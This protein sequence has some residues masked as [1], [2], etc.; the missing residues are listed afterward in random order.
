MPP[1]I[2]PRKWTAP[3]SL[4]HA[5]NLCESIKNVHHSVAVDRRHSKTAAEPP[6][7]LP[8][9]LIR[10]PHPSPRCPRTH[11]RG[12]TPAA[13]TRHC[14]PSQTSAE[15]A[16]RACK[17]T[18]QDKRMTTTTSAREN[19][20]M[21]MRGSHGGGGVWIGGGSFYGRKPVE[22]KTTYC[23]C[24]IIMFNLPLKGS[25]CQAHARQHSSGASK[26]L[27]KYLLYNADD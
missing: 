18:A 12:Y 20:W 23:H 17:F 21:R 26:Q 16:S 14:Y 11:L 2:Y 6:P 10:P 24:I 15:D 1:H 22:L 5:R 7:Y 27:W 3:S 4:S 25:L 9:S 8:A 19:R 13:M